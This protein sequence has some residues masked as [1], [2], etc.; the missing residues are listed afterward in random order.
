MGQVTIQ[1]GSASCQGQPTPAPTTPS[2]TPTN[3]PCTKEVKVSVTTDNYPGETS[4]SITSVD[5]PGN[6]LMSGSNYDN[7]GA[8]YSETAHLTCGK[9]YKFTINDAY[10]DGICCIYGEGNYIVT[11]EGSIVSQGGEFGSTE[12]KEFA[13]QEEDPSPTNSPI[14]SPT[15]PPTPSP[16][17]PP[18]P[19]PTIASNSPVAPTSPPVTS[20]NY[21]ETFTFSLTTDMYGY[22]TS[23]TLVNELDGRL[24]FMGGSYSSSKTLQDS[25]CL[26]NGRYI[27]TI[28]DSHGD[29]I[30][31]G[32]QGDGSYKITLGDELI[33]QGGDFGESEQIV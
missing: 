19:S 23:F 8:I 2:P 1:L 33:G 5:D 17:N 10:G 29:G 25:T 21:C 11:V 18:T 26:A 16:T 31:C 14:T 7:A 20:P 4:W 15:N 24:R 32:S 12:I 30:C 22:E 28:S 27:F 6:D 13:I 3:G 9:T